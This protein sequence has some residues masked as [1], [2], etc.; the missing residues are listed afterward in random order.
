MK[1]F[2]VLLAL[3]VGTLAAQTA[4]TVTLAGVPQ[5][6]PT[7]T[8]GTV[9]GYTVFRGPRVPALLLNSMHRL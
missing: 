3:A 1:R 5:G 9:T 2:L 8:T 4:R 7:G 6:P